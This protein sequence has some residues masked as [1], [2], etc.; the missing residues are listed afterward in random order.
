MNNK[1]NLLVVT[2]SPRG[3]RS[4]SRQLTSQFVHHWKAKGCS[5]LL[6]ARDVG[7]NPPPYV[8]EDWIAA[9]FTA[10]Q[11]RTTAM[12]RA[13]AYSDSAIGELKQADVLVL[14]TPMYNYGLPAALKAWVDQIVR[15]NETF[16]FDLARGDYP[17]EPILKNKRL[18]VLS[19]SGEFGFAPAGVRESMNH[20]HPH[21]ETLKHYL[22]VFRSWYASIEYQ[23]F[24]DDRFEASKAEAF[25]MVPAIVDEIIESFASDE[26]SVM[27]TI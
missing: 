15:V 5:G 9:A 2:G 16:S 3:E 7:R 10:P 21:I 13:L 19:S 8:S 27:R 4:L 26:S 25:A 14:A 20:L 23:E 12:R 18:V 11:E 1:Q 17:L 6:V 24:G 22:G